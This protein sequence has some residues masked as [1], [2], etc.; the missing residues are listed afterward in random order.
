MPVAPD[1]PLAPI[2]LLGI[3]FDNATSFRKGAALAP[4]TIRS[5]TPH[6]TP[7][8]EERHLLQSALLSDYGDVEK[9]LD[10][11][12]Y[13]ATVTHE[14]SQ[15]LRHRFA[16]FL[17][18]DHSV[19]IPLV[20]AYSQADP[21]PFGV[22]HLDAHTDLMDSFEGHH[23]SHACTARRILEYPLIEPAHYVF[24]GI[25]SWEKDEVAFLQST[26]AIQVHSARSVHLAGIKAT[27]EQIIKSMEGIERIYL[28]LDIDCLDPA[29]APGTGTPES[30]GFTSRDL[31]DLLRL[32][33]AAL[34]INALDIVEISPT[35]DYSDITAV[36]AVK[37]LY[38]VFG[39]VQSR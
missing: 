2:G 7:I 26:P 36:A 24:A 29:Y 22:I 1:A 15:V 4:A 35:L 39:W 5:L 28:T 18:G 38:E 13:F 21:R 9:D 11:E 33:F 27:A 14:A 8:T 12:R 34:P 31:L 20:L 37:V 25:R 32:L 17:G 23:W 10:W 19:T 16:I 30:G 6:V 3:P